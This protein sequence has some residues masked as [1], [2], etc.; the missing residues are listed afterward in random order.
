[1]EGQRPRRFLRD[2]ISGLHLITYVVP[3]PTGG[4]EG[5]GERTRLGSESLGKGVQEGGMRLS[6]RE[7]PWPTVQSFSHASYLPGSPPPLEEP[8]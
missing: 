6:L 1:M 8:V 7:T 4:L 3:S 2:T 5:E